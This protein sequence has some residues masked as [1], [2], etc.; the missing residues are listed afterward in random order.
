VIVIALLILQILFSGVYLS[1]TNKIGGLSSILGWFFC[2]V[3]PLVTSFHV[4]TRKTQQPSAC[5]V[6]HILSAYM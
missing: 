1:R 2:R 3:F 5:A 4:P 6:K